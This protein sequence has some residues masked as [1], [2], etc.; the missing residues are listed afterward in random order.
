MLLT[1]GPLM[2][3]RGAGV[4]WHK[5]GNDLRTNELAFKFRIVIFENGAIAVA[6]PIVVPSAIRCLYHGHV[7]R[8]VHVEYFIKDFIET[9]HPQLPSKTS[10]LPSFRN[11]YPNTLTPRRWQGMK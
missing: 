4:F 6:S 7:N 1:I 3:E 2:N 9:M 5:W 10:P 11:V 8:K